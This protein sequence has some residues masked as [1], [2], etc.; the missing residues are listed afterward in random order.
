MASVQLSWFAV[1]GKIYQVQFLD[2]SNLIEW[3]N[4][5]APVPGTDQ[6]MTRND[7][8][9]GKTRRLYRVLETP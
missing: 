5:G 2:T 4:D 1:S 8:I 6:L 9:L 3:Q 7:D